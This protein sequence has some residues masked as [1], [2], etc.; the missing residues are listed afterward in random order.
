MWANVGGAIVD[1]V[2]FECEYTLNAIPKATAMLPVGREVMTMLPSSAHL[3]A[4]QTQI[5]I[6]TAVY[7]SVRYAGGNTGGILPVGDYLLFAGWTTGIGY[8][9]SYGGLSMA[10]EITHWLSALTYSS[11]MSESSHPHNPASFAF[12]SKIKHLGKPGGG[13][14]GG[15]WMVNTLARKYITS[16]NIE[17]DL[18]NDGLKAMFLDL[19]D[20]DRFNW[21][22]FGGI[23]EPN[24]SKTNDCK[25]ALNTFAGDELP[26][27]TVGLGATSA[28]LAKAMADD[29][30]FAT[31]TPS[32]L[33]EFT[34][35]ASTTFWD[36]LLSLAGPYR[37]AVIPFPHKALVVPYVAGLR[38][39]WDPYGIG[40]TVLARDLDLYN[41]NHQLIR[42]LRAIGVYAGHGSYNGAYGPGNKRPATLQTVGGWYVGRDDGLVRMDPAPRYMSHLIRPSAFSKVAAG[43]SVPKGNAINPKAG[44][45][46]AGKTP[47]QINEE[48]ESMLNRFAHAIF[49]SE[50]LKQRT[51]TIS[52][53]LRFDIC[54]GSSIRIEGTAGAF[55]AGVD[56]HGEPRHGMVYRVKMG[57]DAQNASAYTTYDVAHF[58]TQTENQNDDTSIARHPIYDKKWIGDFLTVKL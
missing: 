47:K 10:L 38:D 54:P 20:E 40:F 18:W 34:Q 46:P 31:M 14:F 24:D 51:G 17:K 58:R 12:A 4:S 25:R 33:A 53:P 21:Q 19:A 11:I 13:A 26:V 37:F 23:V 32:D 1:I 49:A 15:H 41:T 2:K 52:G 36:K 50:M 44:A 35:M 57:A 7:C 16:A 42:P 8:R 9:H 55:L 6:P 45:K 3:I 56:P 48:Q 22:A 27:D 28:Q 5:Q 29:I 43:V 30:A 39:F